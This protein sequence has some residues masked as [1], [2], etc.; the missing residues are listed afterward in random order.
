MYSSYDIA[1]IFLPVIIS[2]H[3]CATTNNMRNEVKE[4]DPVLSP[5]AVCPV[6]SIVLIKPVAS[7]TVRPQPW[8]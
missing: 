4:L 1:L 3:P 7:R 2:T 6:Y 8:L 5:T